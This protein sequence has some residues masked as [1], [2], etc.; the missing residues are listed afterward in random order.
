MHVFALEEMRVLQS[1]EK[2]GQMK[3]R[4]EIC[5]GEKGNYASITGN[6]RVKI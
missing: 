4:G 6:W 5:D 2:E 1:D 3:C